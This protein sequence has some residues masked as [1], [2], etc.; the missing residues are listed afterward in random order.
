MY[1]KY[2]ELRDK[3][4]IKDSEVAYATGISPATLSDWKK[5]RYTPKADKMKKLA[6]FFGE[7]LETFM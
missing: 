1:T 3:R 7:P 6:D 4:G 5:G 2:A